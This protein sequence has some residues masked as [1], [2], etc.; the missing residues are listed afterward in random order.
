V[1]YGKKERQIRGPDKADEL[2]YLSLQHVQEVV[3][4]QYSGH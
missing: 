4:S 3:Q 2:V 1:K